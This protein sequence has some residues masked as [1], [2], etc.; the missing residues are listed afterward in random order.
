[1]NIGILAGFLGAWCTNAGTPVALWTHHEF[2][3]TSAGY[4]CHYRGDITRMT[5]FRA[6]YL[7]CSE[8]YDLKHFEPL[9]VDVKFTLSRFGLIEWY[10][11]RY[12]NTTPKR[13]LRKC[14]EPKD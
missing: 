13:I 1:M 7:N 14:D 5:T 8:I 4:V 6:K 12:G 2:V 10:V 3:D 11:D 9:D